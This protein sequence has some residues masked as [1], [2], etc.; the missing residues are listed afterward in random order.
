MN[1]KVIR[2]IIYAS[3]A[4]GI[5]AVIVLLI[6]SSIQNK[7]TTTLLSEGEGSYNPPKNSNFLDR[8]LLGLISEY[9]GYGI[10]LY[11]FL[12]SVFAGFLS[13]LIGLERQLMGE[14][15][16]I[17]T[18]A[19]ISIGSSLLMTISI[20]AIRIAD[21]SIDIGQGSIS[22]SADLNYDTSRIAAGVVTGLGFLG[23]GVIIHD[24]FTVK[25]LATAGTLWICAAIG[26]ACG[27][28]FVLEAIVTTVVTIIT[29]IVLAKLIDIID[30]K[31]PTLTV[32]AKKG[33]PIVTE[34]RDFS[35]DNGLT[36]KHLTID[37]FT[38]EYTMVRISYTF[39]TDVSLLLYLQEQLLL[40][41][42]ILEIKI[43]KNKDKKMLKL[44]KR[45]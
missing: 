43:L 42:E 32:K 37:E 27:A 33:F 34:I 44:S 30:S 3:I 11:V 6:I 17:R 26:L 5:I 39:K 31:S 40:N 13:F 12:T 25:G 29:L 14:A 1:K 4:L 9:N 38:D 2:N 41:P 16:G 21:G 23:G 15:A 28:G 18:H 7:T 24:K 22:V 35:F 10:L 20:W 36:L 8:W 19:L 45:G